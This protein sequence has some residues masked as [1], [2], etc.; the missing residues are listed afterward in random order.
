MKLRKWLGM[1]L[2]LMMVVAV[3]VGITACGVVKTPPTQYVTVTWYD[4]ETELGKNDHHEKGTVIANDDK[5]T[6][7]ERE[8]Y[9]YDWYT[10]ADGETKFDFSQ[11]IEKDT[12]IYLHWTKDEE[13]PASHTH[14][15]GKWE[16]TQKPTADKEG[17]AQRVC[18]AEGCDK[19]TETKVLPVLSEANYNIVHTNPVSCTENGLDTYTLKAETSI[20]FTVDVLTTGHS[21]G[22]LIAEQPATCT[23]DGTRAHYHCSVC[24]K[25][26]L[27]VDGKPAATPA[28]AEQLKIGKLGHDYTQSEWVI[29]KPEAD[30]EGK[31]EKACS[32]GE[33]HE[34]QSVVLPKLS[35]EDKYQNITA[36]TATCGAGG[37]R[38]YTYHSEYGDITFTV[39]TPA[40][41]DHSLGQT[42]EKDDTHHWKECSVCHQH[43]QETAHDTDGYEGIEGACSVCGYK[44][45]DTPVE[46]HQHQFGNEWTVTLKPTAD[47]E[48][49]AQR[50]CT[51]EDCDQTDGYIETKVL[52]KLSEKDKYTIGHTQLPSCTQKGVDTYKLQENEAITFTVDVD[53]VPHTFDEEPTWTWEGNDTEGYTKAT[54]TFT[55]SVCKEETH[56]EVDNEIEKT[57]SSDECA[58]TTTYTAE[59]N[60]NGHSYTK[61]KS[62]KLNDQHAY[63]ELHPGKPATCLEEGEK[64]H[65]QCSKCHKYFDKDHNEITDGIVIP[66]KPHNMQEHEYKAPT[67]T[68]PGNQH[69]YTCQNEED[70]NFYKDNK[71]EE[72]WENEQATVIPANG[73]TYEEVAEQPATCTK[74]GVAKHYHCDGCDQDFLHDKDVV[75]ATP[76]QLKLTKLAHSYPDN[77]TID[78]PAIGKAGTATKTCTKC[79]EGDEGHTLSVTLP[80]L[81]AE[82]DNYTVEHTRPATCTA[83]GQDTYKLKTDETI[84]FTVE[85]EA[86]GHDFENSTKWNH[87]DDNHWKVCKNCDEEDTNKE[88]HE[89][90]DGHCET[91]GAYEKYT[92]SFNLGDAEDEGLTPVGPVTVY[93]ND[94]KVNLPGAPERKDYNFTGWECA[95]D[96]NTYTQNQ[97]YTATKSTTFTAQWE[98]IPAKQCTYNFYLTGNG[99]GDLSMSGAYGSRVDQFRMRKT[100]SGD[101]TVYTFDSI[102]IFEGD[103][104]KIVSD[105]N[106]GNMW[107][108]GTYFSYGD[109]TGSKTNFKSSDGS[110]TGNIQATASG[111]YKIV[112][113]VDQTGKKI[114]FEIITLQIYT[115]VQQEFK[116]YYLTGFMTDPAWAQ[117]I[118]DYK[119]EGSNNTYTGVFYL[120][121]NKSHATDGKTEVKVIKVTALKVGEREAGYTVVWYGLSGT[122]NNE[123]N[124]AISSTGWYKFT[125][126]VSKGCFTANPATEHT[127]NYT[128][129]IT[130]PTEKGEGQAIGT[131]HG[132]GDVPCDKKEVTLTLPALSD[133]RYQV[134]GTPTCREGYTLDYKIELDEDEVKYTV[135]FSITYEADAHT[136][137]ES[138]W[139]SDA[140]HHWHVCS[141]CSTEIEKGTHD[142]GGD[143]VCD[144]CQY[145]AKKVTA[146]FNVGYGGQT[147]EDIVTYADE[148]KD[149]ITLPTPNARTGYKFDG[150]VINEQEPVTGDYSLDFT[151]DVTLNFTAK[152]TQNNYT[153]K[154]DLGGGEGSFVDSGSYQIGADIKLPEGEPTRT[155]YKFAGW[156]VAGHEENVSTS[157]KLDEAVITALKGSFEVT[158][159]ANWEVIEYTIR[160][161]V[162]APA[163][164]EGKIQP[165]SV[166]DIEHVTIEAGQITLQQL[167][168]L[169]SHTFEGWRLGNA[170]GT[171]YAGESTTLDKTIIKA[172][173]D[174]EGKKVI[175]FF[176][177]WQEIGKVTAYFD[178]GVSEMQNPDSVSVYSGNEITFPAKQ[179]R[180]GYTFKGWHKDGDPETTLHQPDDTLAISET[181]TFKAV[182]QPITY[183]IV[184]QSDGSA[185]TTLSVT[186]ETAAENAFNAP[187]A[188]DGYTFDGWMYG[189]QKYSTL[190]AAL[191]EAAAPQDDAHTI[192]LTAK[193]TAKIYKVVYEDGVASEEI[194][195]PTDGK[196]Y[197]LGGDNAQITLLQ[198][199]G[200]RTGYDFSK[201]TLGESGKYDA[202]ETIGL[203]DVIE[204]AQ[205]ISNENVITFKAE[206]TKHQ[207]TVTFDNGAYG[208]LKTQSVKVEYQDDLDLTLADYILEDTTEQHFLGWKQEGTEGNE[209]LKNLTVT[210]DV[211]LVAV[212]EAKILV[213]FEIDGSENKTVYV[214]KGTAIPAEEFP[215]ELKDACRFDGWYNGRVKFEKQSP[216]E[217]ELTLTGTFVEQVTITF[218]D[219][220]FTNGKK[221]NP[222]QNTTVKI[223]KGTS[224]E[225]SPVKEGTWPTGPKSTH[226]YTGY[227]FDG[228]FKDG[229]K[230]EQTETID[231]DITLTAEYH[232]DE[233]Q[234]NEE[235]FALVGTQNTGV[236]VQ[237][238]VDTESTK[239]TYKDSQA[240]VDYNAFIL[241]KD[242][243]YVN[244]TTVY[245]IYRK[246]VYME[247]GN[248]FKIIRKSAGKWDYTFEINWTHVSPLN[249]AKGLA[250]AKDDSNN[251]KVSTS[252]WYTFEFYISKSAPGHFY[253]MVGSTL[254][255]W[256]LNYKTESKSAPE[257]EAYIRGDMNNWMNGYATNLEWAYGIAQQKEEIAKYKMKHEGGV[258]T[259]DVTVE[260]AVGFKVFDWYDGKWYGTASNGNVQ[261]SSKGTWRITWN[262]SGTPTAKKINTYTYTYSLGEA[263]GYVTDYQLPEGKSENSL[264]PIKVKL[265]ETD[266][267]WEGYKFKGW[268]LNSD[269]ANLHA[270]GTEVTLVAGENTITAVW[271]KLVKVTFKGIGDDGSDKVVTI[272]K[273]SQV[274]D[275]PAVPEKV[276]Y[277]QGKWVNGGETYDANSTFDADITLT[278]SYTAT[279]YT[280]E[281]DNNEHGT[282]P[283][284]ATVTLDSPEIDLSKEPYVLSQKGYSF[285]GWEGEGLEGQ[286]F[287]LTPELI[288]GLAG[289][290]K[291]FT[292]TAQWEANP[293]HVVFAHEGA[294]GASATGMPKDQYVDLDNKN[295]I[296]LTGTPQLENYKF[297]Y[298]T[299]QGVKE[300]TYN[301]ET[302]RFTDAMILDDSGDKITVTAHWTAADKFSISFTSDSEVTAPEG[303]P[304]GT[305]VEAGEFD[306]PADK[307]TRKG[308]TFQGWYVGEDQDILYNN[309]DS[310]HGKYDVTDDVEF[311]AKWEAIEY[312]LVFDDTQGHQQTADSI[313]KVTLQSGS[314]AMPV[315]DDESKP[316]FGYTFQGWQSVTIES[317]VIKG[318]V[319]FNL[320]EHA[321]LIPA[322]EEREI[323]FKATWEDTEYQVTFAGEAHG[324]NLP[325][326]TTIMINQQIDLQ[327]LT[328]DGYTFDGWQLNADRVIK[329]MTYTLLL[330]DINATVEA[331]GITFTAQW[332]A[333]EY[334]VTFKSYSEATTNLQSG[335]VKYNSTVTPPK[336]PTLAGYTFKQ[337]T[338]S[339]GETI[340]KGAVSWTLNVTHDVTFY[341]DW[342]DDG[343]GWYMASDSSSWDTFGSMK[344]FTKSHTG[345]T[346]TVSLTPGDMIKFLYKPASY[347]LTK[348]TTYNWNNAF[349]YCDWNYKATGSTSYNVKDYFTYQD[350]NY[351]GDG[352]AIVRYNGSYTFTMPLELKN[353]AGTAQTL[354][355]DCYDSLQLTKAPTI[356][357]TKDTVTVIIYNE[358]SQYFT[359]GLCVHAWH[360]GK[361]PLFGTDFPGQEIKSTTGTSGSTNES[362]SHKWY[363]KRRN[364]TSDVYILTFEVSKNRVNSSL[365]I[366]VSALDSG[367]RKQTYNLKVTATTVT[368][369]TSNDYSPDNAAEADKWKFAAY[370][371]GFKEYWNS[372]TVKS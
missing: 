183:K 279:S 297:A 365:Y 159:Q 296:D 102:D 264:D 305:Q 191:I 245:T 62:V 174:S 304:A 8:D 368:V 11:K 249:S 27:E 281:F 137:D 230:Y 66:K 226:A 327:Q 211:K 260:K 300:H 87:D 14:N 312:T 270:G 229:K 277:E 60:Y 254:T 207:Y 349:G 115:N 32:R 12:N 54:A 334:T 139:H 332:T 125:L 21:Y 328:A 117:K 257:H 17:S 209:T 222:V 215:S 338:A 132:S 111:Q 107:A 278:A 63:G 154:Y 193:W 3:A 189:E 118:T 165:E 346:L 161:D 171:L 158:V 323:K 113:T 233:N 147:I 145:A 298:W 143:H 180:T 57:S 306:I 213:T 333:Q 284:A 120:D 358:N 353:K 372:G 112:L 99:A 28:T 179:D 127:H 170:N 39:N 134:T 308:Y 188:K 19:P 259:I 262:G 169:T 144:T 108:E 186:L 283:E 155:G 197:S 126:T 9:T 138:D 286:T 238:W 152:W 359:S 256:K 310:T 38:T 177:S 81:D 114:S 85:T 131:C 173:Q 235:M 274:T 335:T 104:F 82:G 68:D 135:T 150:W 23:A 47:V 75:P 198:M 267:T 164:M 182:W 311:K 326:G 166:T 348:T 227:I 362:T 350:N 292:L 73:H 78:P 299:I 51:A 43:L 55:C 241:V 80:A 2:S 50:V 110:S 160:F 101:N 1:L 20:S 202:D 276:G 261:L 232:I 42:W 92:L 69:Y 141:K 74:E 247:S 272:E 175:T 151:E 212:W 130:N 208:E 340:A 248:I 224:Y 48:G 128:W 129:Q 26:F 196:S 156:T 339:T 331:D 67:C 185:S 258:Y 352:N 7:E 100:M 95:A 273:G 71:G 289:G 123:G 86:T 317:L 252:G 34:K 58:D 239:S 53:M 119:L 324:N 336:Q 337:W 22:T 133:N 30:R 94:P 148:N 84:S 366:I 36:D 142:F 329:D 200:T 236:K 240:N 6:V 70:N 345:Y 15:Y 275:W 291:S 294:D 194:Q 41:G 195:V 203:A 318:N 228:W 153:V 246:T 360:A 263:A 370:G 302:V 178:F 234:L 79:Q 303:M 98:K 89:F 341:G 301:N 176:A 219:L 167:S 319:N 65:F 96:G 146:K 313:T 266:P 356:S 315:I 355:K 90:V 231:A 37:E 220:T 157:F 136:Y 351:G 59:V 243:I 93:A 122:S 287:K 343:S 280:V 217:G 307:P 210:A 237:S 124:Y 314:H 309:G 290:T 347:T 162:N 295:T 76:E 225:E 83:A 91:C 46:P 204:Y 97:Q 25:D 364:A 18:S 192:T 184:F 52:P 325:G 320:A 103:N 288:Q 363:A 269:K 199:T 244:G 357:T 168:G 268:Q 354:G 13:P 205:V 187:A 271:V 116:G 10:S 322:G 77:W 29:T 16:V 88:P 321:D 49:S 265:P 255:L 216:V 201:W 181:T 44:K 367:A 64:E 4:G 105:M 72:K 316:V 190:T 163:E 56:T 218:M 106:P 45:N 361:S 109:I 253:A 40:T 342:E 24:E 214:V 172:A 35:E 223:D 285:N 293:Y 330:S 5:P 121:I 31:A 242:E 221:G 250:D 140:T 206:W 149:S 344:K 369:Q 251:I 282:K 371:V 61:T 33:D